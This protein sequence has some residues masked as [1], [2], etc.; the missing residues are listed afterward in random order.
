MQGIKEQL[1]SKCLNEQSERMLCYSHIFLHNVLK[2][3]LSTQTL[4]KEYRNVNNTNETDSMKDANT[5]M[6]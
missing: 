5:Y 6:H 4:A 3:H 1:L 2:F